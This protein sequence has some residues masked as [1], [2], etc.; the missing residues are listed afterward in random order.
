MKYSVVIPTY[1]RATDLR[2]TLG[3]LAEIHSPGSW[4]VIVVDNNSTDGTP[5]T[6]AAVAAAFPVEL[7]YV[8]EPVQGISAALNAGIGAA[9]GELIAITNDDH[10]YDRDWL[11]SAGVSWR[12]GSPSA[13]RRARFPVA[14]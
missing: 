3:S 1:N 5:E 10:R 14:C 12:C 4:E 2:D 13:R 7:R 8:H 6:I 11:I 9:S